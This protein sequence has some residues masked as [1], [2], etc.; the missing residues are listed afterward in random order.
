MFKKRLSRSEHGPLQAISADCRCEIESIR[1]M[2]RKYGKHVWDEYPLKWNWNSG[3]QKPAVDSTIDCGLAVV[4][5]KWILAFD[6]WCEFHVLDEQ[7]QELRMVMACLDVPNLT[8]ETISYLLG[9]IM[10]GRSRSSWRNKPH[11]WVLRL[12]LVDHVLNYLWCM[13]VCMY[14]CMCV[15]RYGCMDV[16]IYVCMYVYI[17]LIF[18][19]EGLI[20]AWD[21]VL[22]CL[23]NAFKKTI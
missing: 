21:C 20:P 2:E 11:V 13:Y 22:L 7:N 18:K 4:G 5:E 23:D 10:S 3:L 6:T 1:E 17:D 15:C 16:S 9:N 8:S 12:L 14:V 19:T